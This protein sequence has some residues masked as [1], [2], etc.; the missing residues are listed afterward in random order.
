MT[1]SRYSTNGS[2][3]DGRLLWAG[4]WG[5]ASSVQM[6]S[7]QDGRSRKGKPCQPMPGN[8]EN[9]QESVGRPVLFKADGCIP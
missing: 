6:A 8:I 1:R 5:S 4:L 3:R 2:G 9:P 7:G